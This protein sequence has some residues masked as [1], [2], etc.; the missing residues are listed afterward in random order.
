VGNSRKKGSKKDLRGAAVD[1]PP[2]PRESGGKE[3]SV[4]L[5]ERM[6]WFVWLVPLSQ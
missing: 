4:S 6:E 5:A 2:R 3:V 1:T